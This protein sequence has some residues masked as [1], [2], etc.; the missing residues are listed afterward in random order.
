MKIDKLYFGVRLPKMSYATRDERMQM[1]ECNLFHNGRILQSVARWVVET[2]KDPKFEKDH[3][4]LM[5]C[6]GDVRSRSEYEWVIC[7]WG[8]LDENDKVVDVGKKV[9]VYEMYVKPNAGLL[10][11]MVNQVSVTSA[12]NYLREEKKKWRRR[13]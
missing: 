2:N 12:K 7:P 3:D 11:E 9:D 8:R 13:K 1:E 6:F 10:R 5:W 4:F